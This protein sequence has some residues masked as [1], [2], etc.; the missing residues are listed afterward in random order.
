MPSRLD[1]EGIDFIK[2]REGFRAKAYRPT[3]NDKWTIGYGSTYYDD[4][5]PIREGDTISKEA[6]E[7]LFINRLKE[8]EKSVND[9]IKTNLTQSQYNALVSLSYNI[10]TSAFKKSTVVKLINNNG[11]E[12]DIA[13]AFLKWTYQK[14]KVLEGLVKRRT[15]EASMFLNKNIKVAKKTIKDN[16]IVIG[17]PTILIVGAII[18]LIK[19]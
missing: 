11:N 6:A 19:K 4:G 18:Y 15:A 1:Q 16:P 10:G 12:N 7:R 3:P 5:S 2:A 9:S 14:G 13:A 8:Y 17:I